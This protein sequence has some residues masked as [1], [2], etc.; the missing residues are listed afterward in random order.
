MS[1]SYFA[2]KND[3]VTGIAAK[4]KPTSQGCF[5]CFG[6]SSQSNKFQPVSSRGGAAA[7]PD[8]GQHS[9]LQIEKK[10]RF[11]GGMKDWADVMNEISYFGNEAKIWFLGPQHES[12]KC[13]HPHLTYMLADRD[14]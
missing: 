13:T 14:H 2:S 5:S 6:L 1:Q 11:E 9:A 4:T 10:K 3:R 7:T 12:T 8:S